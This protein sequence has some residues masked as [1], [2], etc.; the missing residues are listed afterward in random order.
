M[1]NA[2][3]GEVDRSSNR[4]GQS[5]RFIA[6]ESGQ[7]IRVRVLDE[8]PHTIKV[9]KISQKVGNEEVFRSIPATDKPD[10][11][12]I[13][14]HNGKRYPD[15]PQFN[16]RVFAYAKDAQGKDVGDSGE[17]K[18]LQG[19]PAIF[20]PLRELYTQFGHLNGFDIIISRK[21][22]KR[23]TE[24]TVSAA[25]K[26]FDIDVV[27]L[28][29]QLAADVTWAWDQIFLPVTESDQVKMLKEAGF[30]I[31]YDP[32]AAIAAS[33]DFETAKRQKFAFG[34]HK[35]K[36]VGDLIVTDAGYLSWAA[37][38]V[39]SNDDLAAACRVVVNHLNQLESGTPVKQ[40]APSP[41]PQPTPTA[42]APKITV[43]VGPTSSPTP[44]PAP[45]KPAEN[46]A[47]RAALTEQITDYF[48]Q[49]PRFE[50]MQ[51]VVNIVKTH[52]G[53]KTR[54]KDLT[55]PQLESLLGA[56]QGGAK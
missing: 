9:H 22:E 8:E 1:S 42:T 41:A 38:N 6:L 27:N 40:I 48:N 23:D 39:T 5:G 29:N 53:G 51:E 28:T 56:L 25:P 21:G 32:A 19:G 14:R 10:E 3:W 37:D 2:G 13:L 16:L 17:F 35:D 49:D 45:A 24:Y 54:V 18:I 26:S 50:D 52:G 33:M 44:A 47:N 43:K 31:H 34:K 7:S 36:T 20:K 15:A 4:G 55:V 30:D 12:Y 46:T 11:N